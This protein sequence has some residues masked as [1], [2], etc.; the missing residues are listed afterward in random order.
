MIIMISTTFC[1]KKH[2]RTMETNVH[3]GAVII[4][5]NGGRKREPIPSCAPPHVAAEMTASLTPRKSVVCR[6]V[7]GHVPK[8]KVASRTID[9]VQRPQTLLCP[10]HPLKLHK[11]SPFS[12]ALICGTGDAL[13]MHVQELV[14]GPNDA[15]NCI[16]RKALRSLK[17]EQFRFRNLVNVK[18]CAAFLQKRGN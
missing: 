6:R 5:V 11:L 18:F 3:F 12:H 17:G 1:E 13:G 14:L 16:Q 4:G 2:A 9:R 15:S 8:P 7:N 10:C